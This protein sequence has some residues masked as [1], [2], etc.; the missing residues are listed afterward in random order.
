[1]EVNGEM[2]VA[3]QA[4]V[5]ILIPISS[6][7]AGCMPFLTVL[8]SLLPYTESPIKILSHGVITDISS[9]NM[10]ESGA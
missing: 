3:Q 5:I 10:D 6:N 7:V 2:S 4:G 9:L 8:L 1:M